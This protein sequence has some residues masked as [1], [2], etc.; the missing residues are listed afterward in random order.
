MY[1]CVCMYLVGLR[2]SE[3]LELNS[4]AHRFSCPWLVLE[5]VR[6]DASLLHLP[7]LPSRVEG[8]GCECTFQ[9]SGLRVDGSQFMVQEVGC[10][11]SGVGCRV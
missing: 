5:R 3:V 8:A 11:V 9:G 1:V 4:L 7:L 6:V 2:C 10:R